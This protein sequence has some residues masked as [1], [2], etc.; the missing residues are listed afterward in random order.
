L[1]V[2]RYKTSYITRDTLAVAHEQRTGKANSHRSFSSRPPLELKALRPATNSS[3][4][5]VPDPLPLVSL[6][7]PCRYTLT[8]SMQVDVRI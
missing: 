1:V 7:I 3:K 6:P 5:T 2:R 8:P 4:S